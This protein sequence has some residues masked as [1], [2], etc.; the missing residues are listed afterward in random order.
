MHAN[1]VPKHA[2]R[3]SDILLNV[4]RYG[5]TRN[6]ELIEELLTLPQNKIKFTG[7]R[8]PDVAGLTYNAHA[9]FARANMLK[10]AVCN[11]LIRTIIRV[12]SFTVNGLSLIHI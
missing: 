9:S 6:T 2:V 12:N 7:P 10:R 3:I 5:L 8:A 11:R 1:V 4:R